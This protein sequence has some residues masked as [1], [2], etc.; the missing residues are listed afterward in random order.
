MSDRAYRLQLDHLC[1]DCGVAE[2]SDRLRSTY[3]YVIV[4]VSCYIPNSYGVR[5]R[6]VYS[7]EGGALLDTHPLRIRG[8]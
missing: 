7:Y 2:K 3:E 8:V 5:I 4:T 1:V 6:C